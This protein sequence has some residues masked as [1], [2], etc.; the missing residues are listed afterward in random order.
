[1]YC[2][3]YMYMHMGFLFLVENRNAGEGRD[4]LYLLCM[5]YCRCYFCLSKVY[6]NQDCFTNPVCTIDGNRWIAN[7]MYCLY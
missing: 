7:T 3:G 2:H 6:Y 1:M 5:M 4:S